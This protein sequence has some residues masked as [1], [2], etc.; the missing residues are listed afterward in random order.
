MVDHPASSPLSLRMVED[1]TSEGVALALAGE[2]D[3]AG[4]PDLEETLRAAEARDGHLVLDLRELR[5][6]DSTGLSVL[7][8]A[9]NRRAENGAVGLRLVAQPGPVLRVI[10]MCGLDRLFE[11]RVAGAPSRDRATAP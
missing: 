6:I 1:G 5:F 3:L 8:D 7:V 9:H 10:E 4:A 11:I 2:L